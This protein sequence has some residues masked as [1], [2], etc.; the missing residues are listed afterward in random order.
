MKHIYRIC[1]LLAL[2]ACQREVPYVY[3]EG[4]IQP[5][6]AVMFTTYIPGSAQTKAPE[7]EFNARMATYKPV[8]DD[9]EFAIE[10]Y[11]QGVTNALGTS[12]YL[13]TKTEDVY[14]A[15]GTLSVKTGEG[16]K[17]PLYWPGNAKKYGFRATAGSTVLDT[18]Q[19][20]AE[21]LLFQDQLLGFGFEPLWN[22]GNPD[23]ETAL[24]YRTSKE[25]YAANKLT[26]G[27]AEPDQYKKI[28]LY[29]RHQ[30]SLITIRL[31]AGEGVDRSVLKNLENI[32]TVIY[33]YKTED[34][35]TIQ[36]FAKQTTIDYA[37]TDYGGAAT[38]VPT[39][40]FTAVV[41][42][43]DYLT[44]ATTDVIAEI[45]L[46]GQRF[47]FYAQHDFLYTAYT[48]PTSEKHVE[49]VTHMAGYNLTAGKH[50]VITATLGRGSRK[51]LITAYIEDWAETVTSSIVDD[52]GQAGDPIQINSRKELH[53]FLVDNKKNKP[54]NVA[55]IV[56]NSLNL[57]QS[58][59]VDMAWEP[60]PLYCTLNMAGATFY[61]NHQV[62]S[63]IGPSANLVNG[64]V[65]IGNDVSVESPVTANNL[66]TLERINVAP[67]DNHGNDSNGKATKAG[68]AVSNSGTIVSCTSTL[69]V[70]GSSGYV[71]GIAARSVYSADNGNTMPVIDGCTV[72]ARVSGT[73]S[74]L[75][76][77][78]V[79]EAVG[80]VTNNTFI[81]GITLLQDAT[82]FKNVIQHKADQTDAQSV[83][84]SLRAYGNA[85]PTKATNS[86]GEETSNPN[87]NQTPVSDRYD[88]VIDSQAE[89]AAL[90]TST[91]NLT[92]KFYRL[93]NSFTT[94]GWTLGKKYDNLSDNSSSGNVFFKLDGNGK[95]ITTDGM[96]FSNIQ[97]DI[98]DLTLRLGNNLVA[99]PLSDGSD[100]IAALAY[101]VCGSGVT[102][103]NIQVKA[104]PYAIQA[105]TVGGLVVWAYDGAVVEDCHCKARIQVWVSALSAE[106]KKYSGGIVAC[107]A[108]AT[109]TRCEFH[110]TE[111]T[112]YRNTADVYSNLNGDPENPPCT[113]L[114]YGGILGGTAPKGEG[115]TT[116]YPS[117]LITDCSS[118]FSTSGSIQ[119]GSVV[120]YARYVDANNVLTNGMA[121][122]CQGNWWPDGSSAIGTKLDGK[123]VE[124]LIG[125]RNAV[126][127]DNDVNYDPTN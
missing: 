127:P 99:T 35:K 78:I 94:S 102:L 59:N 5:G 73:G 81:Y 1:L 64:T 15:D 65:C 26:M 40:E 55:I 57:E 74:T 16:A 110:N 114:F 98:F 32:E 46:S 48:D 10:M 112:L 96:L 95:T 79:G 122:G 115:A 24:N 120:G 87:D 118:W 91:Y 4:E 62:F 104:G 60:L 19:S 107:A 68:L 12:D 117:V 54:G 6:E 101:A 13:P 93:S 7:D 33:S 61:T 41:E 8:S 9:Y 109:I 69:P 42:P 89:L 71:G 75:G 124:Q 90:L 113:G 52:Y 30:R 45:H 11:K 14:A 72:D 84:Y 82:N 126:T 39:S 20:T 86:V 34:N 116:E 53:D 23:N 125:K 56:P 97:N 25:W 85:W 27:Q 92:D 22:D 77:G 106:A 105:S 50:L 66:G 43:H 111:G 18:D 51:I 103:R 21:K 70:E 47:T 63:L 100:A 49:A 76:G 121:D 123:T 31:K 108:K 119:L 28:P 58:E 36:P 44:G 3:E 38:A 67:K 37:S 17:E 80:R 2:A 88:A 83:A 29:F